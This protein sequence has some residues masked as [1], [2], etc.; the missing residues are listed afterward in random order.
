[1]GESGESALDSFSESGVN[2]LACTSI[3]EVSISVSDTENAG[4]DDLLPVTNI[5]D[6]IYW[7][8]CGKGESGDKVLNSLTDVVESGDDVLVSV[9]NISD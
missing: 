1:M 3:N 8:N 5:I 6:S 4:D 2:D 7:I 9:I